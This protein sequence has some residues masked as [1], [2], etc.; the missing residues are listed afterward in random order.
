M[1]FVLSAMEISFARLNDGD[2]EPGAFPFQRGE[3]LAG[4]L[5]CAAVAALFPLMVARLG[6]KGTG[7][8]YQSFGRHRLKV[9][10]D[11]G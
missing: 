7:A 6:I 5:R 11:A 1:G 8:S 4:G 3:L 9:A 2:A 10:S